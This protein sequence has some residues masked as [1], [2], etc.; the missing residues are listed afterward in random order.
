Q[1]E[2]IVSDQQPPAP[3]TPPPPL[4]P[5][6]PLAAVTPQSASKMVQ[7]LTAD[8]QTKL[9]AQVADFA[10]D[11]LALPVHG[12]DFKTRVSAISA[13][14]NDAIQRASSVS[15]RL[16]DR[17][18]RAMG[19]GIFDAGSNVSKQL[20]DLRDTVERLDPNTQGDLFSPR[21]LLG[22]IPLGPKILAYFRSYESSQTH[23]NAIITGLYS[24]RDQL[25][26]DNA[27]IEQEK[28]NL[29]TLMGQL[30]QFAYLAQ[31]VADAIDARIA[32]VAQTDAERAKILKEDVLFYARQKQQDIATQQ[33][34][35][36]Q[37]YLALDLI[38]KNNEELIKGVDRATTTTIAA[39]RTAIIVAQALTSQKL[40]LD[41]IQAL[42]TTTNRLI[43]DTAT[44][45]KQNTERVFE[46]ATSSSVNLDTLKQAFAD[47]ESAID[48]ISAYKEKA[49]IS[50]QQTVAALQPMIEQAKTYVDKRRDAVAGDTSS[51]TALPPDPSGTAR[52][53]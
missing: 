47:T 20:L 44:M 51:L 8:Q 18:V 52:I 13:M 26:R 31:K 22:L 36:V 12:D 7:P 21:K 23:L 42:N 24:S 49:L 43:A 27:D 14:G 6:A 38:R 9:D 29:W 28:E 17:P 50:F 15:N 10:K 40:V 16:L 32:Q 1:G 3:L 35:N 48:G 4:T 19:G 45:L 39:L 33:A 53:L 37:G 30:E 5:P 2:I 11:L 46:Q 34:V 41:Q 25:L